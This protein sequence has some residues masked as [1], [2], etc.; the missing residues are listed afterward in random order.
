M[1]RWRVV[2]VLMQKENDDLKVVAVELLFLQG[3]RGR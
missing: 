3:R 1:R 2:L